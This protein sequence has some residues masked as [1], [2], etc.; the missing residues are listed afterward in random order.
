MRYLA[1][2]LIFALLLTGCSDEPD[3][4]INSQVSKQLADNIR[5][6][7]RVAEANCVGCHGLDGRGAAPNI[8]HLTS[9]VSEYLRAALLAYKDRLRAHAALQDLAAH[10][11]DA[12][13]RNVAVYYASLPPLKQRS[14]KQMQDFALSPYEQK[15]KKAS[16]VCAACHGE[17]GNST[18][19]GMPTLAGQ[20]PLYTVSAIQSYIDGSRSNIEVMEPNLSRLTKAD[21][22]NIA[23]YYALQKPLKRKTKPPFGDPEKGEPLSAGC[24]GCHGSHGVSKDP[25]TPSLAGQDPTYLVSAIKGYRDRTRH[26][27][28]MHGFV[29]SEVG[30]QEIEHIAAYY[31][32]QKP[33]DPELERPISAKDLVER[34]DRCHGVTV[35]QRGDDAPSPIFPKLDGQH[36]DYL[37]KAL[38]SYRDGKRG[39]GMMH[40]MSLPYSDAI[41]QG[42]ATL[43]A[44]RPQR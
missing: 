22:D 12:D 17:D 29:V 24:G 30:D 39:S 36:R 18:I 16:S 27:D 26:H 23:L 15:G 20:Q 34:C 13:I 41:I 43:Y 33:Q 25:V 21:M 4:T 9:Q 2:I 1:S 14:P 44:S 28:A 42:V 31:A 7:K 6:G 8:P 37:I 35:E 5:A 40:K 19:A 38:R 11:T 3:T 10:M 32:V